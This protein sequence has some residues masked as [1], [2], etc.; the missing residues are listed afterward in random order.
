MKRSLL[1]GKKVNLD[2]ERRRNILI[3]STKLDG[4]SISENY[5]AIKTGA[6]NQNLPRS[7]PAVAFLDYHQS[8]RVISAVL[9]FFQLQ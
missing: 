5:W 8:L 3:L 9:Y 6:E 4:P 1:E 7:L 2:G